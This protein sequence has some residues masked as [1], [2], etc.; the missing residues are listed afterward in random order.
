MSIENA[1]HLLRCSHVLGSNRREFHMRA[2]LLGTMPDGRLKL[3]VFG[4]LFWKNT[5][6]ISRIRYVEAWR[7]SE[8]PQPAQ[9]GD[10]G[11]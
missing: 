6:H 4:R 5:E 11:L 10:H 7:V 1:K 2:E 9:G 8:A 3:R